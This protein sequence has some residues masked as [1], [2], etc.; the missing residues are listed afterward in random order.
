MVGF[1]LAVTALVVGC[2]ESST[3]SVSVA[4]EASRAWPPTLPEPSIGPIST[5]TAPPVVSIPGKPAPPDLAQ[6][7][8]SLL[9]DRSADLERRSIELAEFEVAARGSSHTR[10]AQLSFS[11]ATPIDSAVALVQSNQLAV[12]AFR[13]LAP[14]PDGITDLHVNIALNDPRADQ[15]KLL[16]EGIETARDLLIHRL[17]DALKSTNSNHDP[18]S[19][20]LVSQEIERLRSGASMSI[21]RIDVVGA[22]SD[23]Y[24]LTK[25]ASVYAA[26]LGPD[27]QNVRPVVLPIDRAAILA[28]ERACG[29]VPEGFK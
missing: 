22:V 11:K 24:A 12:A 29:S 6:H 10:R 7:C 3:E 13:A 9:K 14:F 8:E 2:R 15:R 17:S 4:T 21:D 19:V 25:H 5:D 18:S 27:S 16:D 26:S 28:V 1:V 20:A 23:L